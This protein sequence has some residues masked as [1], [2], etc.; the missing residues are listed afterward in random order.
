MSDLSVGDV[1][2]PEDFREYE[3]AFRNT[4][5]RVTHVFK[6]GNIRARTDDGSWTCWGPADGYYRPDFSARSCPVSDVVA[7]AREALAAC[8]CHGDNDDPLME[9]RLNLVSDLVAEVE[10]LEELR[11]VVAS[12]DSTAARIHR[13]WTQTRRQVKEL[14]AEIERLRAE[15]LG[16]G[17]SESDLV[18]QL[19]A[20]V[21]DLQLES[22]V[23]GSRTL[24]RYTTPWKDTTK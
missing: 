1:I 22:K 20:E 11:S 16:M 2:L 14:R 10:E 13:Q 7:R 6:N 12:D 5:L 4:N 18:V 17:I 23:I 3:P 21:A 15:L 24:T 19:R 8:V 9:I